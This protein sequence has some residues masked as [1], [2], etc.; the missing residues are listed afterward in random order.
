MKSIFLALAMSTSVLASQSPEWTGEDRETVCRV[1]SAFETADGDRVE[2]RVDAALHHLLYVKTTI[3]GQVSSVPTNL[4]ENL[5]A[6]STA[7]VDWRKSSEPDTMELT[8]YSNRNCA[9]RA[10]EAWTHET[11]WA[12]VTFT[13]FRGRVT[14]RAIRKP[15][16]DGEPE[17][18]VK[19]V[20][21]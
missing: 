4:L 18:I 14:R 19:M 20:G 2:L 3:A 6:A 15:Y 7:F 9:P 16:I 5:T 11:R 10:Y 21:P 12:A 13:F 1:W 8:I 17:I